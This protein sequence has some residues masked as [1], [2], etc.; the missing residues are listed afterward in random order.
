[1][2]TKHAGIASMV[3]VIVG[4]GVAVGM[5]DGVTDGDG[6]GAAATVTVNVEVWVFT[7]DS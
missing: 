1:M 6:I 7:V 5:T 3:W 2:S 4:F